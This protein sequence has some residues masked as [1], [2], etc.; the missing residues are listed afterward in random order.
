MAYYFILYMSS[1]LF[2]TGDP[3]LFH[4]GKLSLCLQAQLNLFLSSYL[5][6]ISLLIPWES[7]TRYKKIVLQQT[8]ALLIN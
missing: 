2:V 8:S 6:F 3:T 5:Y 4:P 7:Y 1:F